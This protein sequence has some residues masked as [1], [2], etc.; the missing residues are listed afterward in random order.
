[1][2]VPWRR[3]GLLDGQPVACPWSA[4]TPPTALPST[5]RRSSTSAWKAGLLLCRLAPVR[6]GGREPRPSGFATGTSARR[7]PWA[8][9]P[10]W[11]RPDLRGRNTPPASPAI[12]QLEPAPW[13]RS[14]DRTQAD[15]P[16][17][18]SR[19][20]IPSTRHRDDRGSAPPNS[21][22]V[23]TAIPSHANYDY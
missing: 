2:R 15:A 22:A 8:H 5:R 4:M 19:S 7:S 1:V 11:D 3:S 16:A 20:D 23:Y 18:R 17:P 13:S 10:G 9:P 12:A 14:A 21:A 6:E